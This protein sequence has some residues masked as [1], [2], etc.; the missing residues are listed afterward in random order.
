GEN[1]RFTPTGLTPYPPA[2]IIRPINSPGPGSF[3]KF[4]LINTFKRSGNDSDTLLLSSLPHFRRVWQGRSLS[5]VARRARAGE[6][7]KIRVRRLSPFHLKHP[8]TRQA[9]KP[10]L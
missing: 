6:V 5:D 1:E 7:W 9:S 10:D 2:R 8:R 4:A 3:P